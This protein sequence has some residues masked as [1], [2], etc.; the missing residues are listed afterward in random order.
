MRLSSPSVK[1]F[2][3]IEKSP[4]VRGFFV[5]LK[6]G[7][8]AMNRTIKVKGMARAKFPPDSITVALTLEAAD[9]DYQKTL[10]IA[11]EKLVKLQKAAA[12]A[13]FEKKELK[14]SSFNVADEYEY[15]QSGVVGNNRQF[16]GYKCSHLLNL[17]FGMDMERLGKALAALS[18]CKADSEFHISF[19]VKDI[20]PL[21]KRLLAQAVRDAAEKAEI[22]AEAAG[23]KLKEI[24]AIT[25]GDI[26]ESI[27]SPTAFN[28]P[29]SAA[30]RSVQLDITP[31]NVD[32]DVSVN[33][34][35]EIE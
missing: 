22:L 7:D 25:C 23:L 6:I 10:D 20:D 2:V 26:D 8:R 17:E 13:G 16:V 33:V 27:V 3:F 11:A 4:M 18:E 15:A 24:I 12:A 32:T 35:W 29:V 30:L 5:L 14:T 9:R 19:G 31:E 1:V 34:E 28:Q 21:K